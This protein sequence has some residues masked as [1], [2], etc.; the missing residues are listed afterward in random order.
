MNLLRT[1]IAG[2]NQPC[3]NFI[4]PQFP[5]LRKY[6]TEIAYQQQDPPGET[7]RQFKNRIYN[8]L[9]VMH[10]RDTQAHHIRIHGKYPHTIWNTVWTN[11]Q[12]A[13]V[14]LNVIATWYLVIHDVIS[15]NSRLHRINLAESPNCTPCGTEDTTHHRLIGCQEAQ[16]IWNATCTM[17]ANITR[18]GRWNIPQHWI[19]RPDFQ[20]WPI[21]KHQA[22]TWIQSHHILYILHARDRI[23]MIE[24]LDFMRRA[25]WKLYRAKQSPRPTGNY[26]L[27]LDDIT[28]PAGRI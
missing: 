23:S 28:R 11:V 26:V 3:G 27:V 6:V 14:S 19:I 20:L 16:V 18:T 13:P 4:P 10:Q 15:N 21:Q 17:L 9:I 2:T 1:D 7:E 25:R 8:N 12:Q 5:N 22:V 24:Y